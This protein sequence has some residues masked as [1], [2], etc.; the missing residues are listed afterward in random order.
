MLAKTSNQSVSHDSEVDCWSNRLCATKYA[1]CKDVN[2]EAEDVVGIR[3]QETAGE[4]ITDWED[5]ECSAVS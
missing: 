1:A 5:L 2:I 4:D 3:Y